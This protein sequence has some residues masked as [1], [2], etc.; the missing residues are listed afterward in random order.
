MA[1]AVLCG[2]VDDGG[3]EK[4]DGDGPLVAGDDGAADP[5]GSAL[6]LVHGDEGGNEAD[7]EASK[8]AAD[9]E[10]GEVAGAC[11]EG[12]AEAEDESGEHD[13]DATSKDVGG[14]TAKQGTWGQ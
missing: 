3:E 4:A 13:A 14:G 5:A 11:L 8:D 2:V 10:G 6:G 7:A 1:V 9:D 12:D